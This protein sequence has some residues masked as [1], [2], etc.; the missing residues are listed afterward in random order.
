MEISKKRISLKFSH[1]DFPCA[2]MVDFKNTVFFLAIRK[3]SNKKLNGKRG[4]VL[5]IF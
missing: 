2:F 5:S 3:N 1:L 4:A